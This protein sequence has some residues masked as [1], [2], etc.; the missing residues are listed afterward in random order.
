M[1]DAAML[2]AILNANVPC[3]AALF[4]RFLCETLA[5]HSNCPNRSDLDS[6]HFVF[7]RFL[8]ICGYE[9]V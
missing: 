9:I 7:C 1:R 2:S 6:L 4:Q 3:D 8:M 5:R